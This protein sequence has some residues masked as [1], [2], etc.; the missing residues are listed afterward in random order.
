VNAVTR[1]PECASVGF[2]LLAQDADPKMLISCIPTMCGMQ[3]VLVLIMSSLRSIVNTTLGFSCI[4]LGIK[5]CRV[6]DTMYVNDV[7]LLCMLCCDV[8]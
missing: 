6:M 7:M 4:A 3:D 5:V 2:V 1:G 8:M